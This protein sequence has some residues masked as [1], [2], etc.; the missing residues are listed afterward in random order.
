M[1]ENGKVEFKKSLAELKAGL[2]SIAAILNKHG[3]GELWF[4]VSNDGK[5][6]GLEATEKTLRNLSQS[7]A[8]HIEPKIFPQ[9]N[10]KTI[11]L[12]ASRW[13]FMAKM[14]LT[15]PTEEHI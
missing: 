5:A 6:V 1:K 4:G 13:F 3:S 11:T 12:S 8:A 7:I 9:I 2:V 14:L 15:M 10:K